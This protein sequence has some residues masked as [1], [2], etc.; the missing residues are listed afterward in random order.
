MNNKLLNRNIRTD[1]S[2]IISLHG[3]ANTRLLIST[4]SAKHNTTKQRISGNISV[5]VR[6]FGYNI[7]SNPP[8]S[9]IF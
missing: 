3:N 8:H 5:M 4:L 6:Y 2:N 7:A 9:V 1:I